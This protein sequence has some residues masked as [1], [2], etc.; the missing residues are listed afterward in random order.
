LARA[1]GVANIDHRLM[2]RDMNGQDTDPMAYTLGQSVESLEKLNTALIIGSNI[3]KDHPLL[4]HRIRKAAIS[5]KA[6]ISFINSV[7]YEVRF[8]VAESII[9]PPSEIARDLAAIAKA[10]SSKVNTPPMEGL[11]KLIDTVQ[12]N[13]THQAIADD[14]IAGS[15]STLLLGLQAIQD[16]NFSKIRMLAF[17]IAQMSESRL[18][19]LTHS[20]NTVG[21][22]SV[23]VLPH[24]EAGG[25]SASK[26]GMDVNTMLQNNL[27]A[28]VLLG[29]EPEYDCIDGQVALA[30]VKNAGFVISMSAYKTASMD[31]YADVILP[32]A[33][34]AETAGSFVNAAGKLQSFEGLTRPEGETRPGWKVLRVL[35]NLLDVSGFDYMSVEEV[36]Q[37]AL[38]AVGEIRVDNQIAWQCPTDLGNSVQGIQR[39]TEVPMYSVDAIVRRAASLQKTRD[40][41][42]DAVFVGTQVAA[43][44]GVK[45]NDKIKV[46]QGDRSAILTMKI[47]ER[48]ASSCVRIPVAVNETL[49]LGGALNPVELGKA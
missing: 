12:V 5:N 7:D 19:F 33:T 22:A 44:L 38:Q 16:V 46:V 23:G 42:M 11:S 35:G 10:L 6:K 13:A 28:Y 9:E 3:R 8:P 30:A 29:V 31:D 37:D 34:F 36:N 2:Q 32:I 49:P 26:S 21:A 14:L 43:D 41:Q 4:A 1:L 15:S 20:A 25:K 27:D 45:E 48:I 47:D 39:V 17:A 24:R 40:A 18:G